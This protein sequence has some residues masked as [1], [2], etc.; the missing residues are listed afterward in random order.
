MQKLDDAP[1]T[2][3]EVFYYLAETFHRKNETKQAIQNLERALDSD[4]TL[5]K[6]RELLTKLKG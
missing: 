2:K 5:T 6:A 4:K 1:I 3:A